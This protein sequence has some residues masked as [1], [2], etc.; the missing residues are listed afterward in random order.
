MK[1]SSG[2]II[3]GAPEGKKSESICNPWILIPMILIPIKI[4]SAKPK[5]IIMWDVT[6]KPKG[7]RPIK[8]QKSIKKN[9]AKRI[10]KYLFPSAFIFS[11][12]MLK[13]TNS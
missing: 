2:A 5:V 3:K 10:G 6:V 7:T 8:L 1:T 9:V 12:T 4:V 13:Y 11:E